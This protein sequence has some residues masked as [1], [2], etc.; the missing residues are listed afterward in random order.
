[1]MM[2]HKQTKRCL[3]SNKHVKRCF[4]DYDSV[5]TG[6]ETGILVQ[7]ASSKLLTS[8]TTRP[9]HIYVLISNYQVLIN[10]KCSRDTRGT[11]GI[12]YNG[13]VVG[14]DDDQVLCNITEHYWVQ[15]VV[16]TLTLSSQIMFLQVC[17]SAFK[18]LHSN[19]TEGAHSNKNFRIFLFLKHVGPYTKY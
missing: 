9:P 12:Q 14:V 17:L 6:Q 16:E 11:S 13:A 4:I 15:T 10:S 19:Q 18:H 8:M 2:L 7:V 3:T 1:M 5:W